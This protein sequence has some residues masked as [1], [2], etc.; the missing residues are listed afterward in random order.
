MKKL[1]KAYLVGA[2]PGDPELITVKGLVILKK[3]DVVIYDALVNTALLEICS[4]HTELIYVGKKIGYKELNQKAINKLLVDKAKEGKMVVR[5]KGGDPFV[6]GRGGEEA[7]IL[8]RKGIEIE[9]VPGIS[10]IIGVPAYCGVPVTHRDY[11]S[12]FA[13]FTGHQNKFNRLN[14]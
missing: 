8:K 6:F 10:S 3:A 9:I 2:G 7:E 13:V 11:N 5:L 1:G 4:K 12:S 14:Y